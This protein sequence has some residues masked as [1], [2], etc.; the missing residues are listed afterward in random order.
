MVKRKSKNW[1]KIIA[2]VMKLILMSKGLNTTEQNRESDV[3]SLL[4]NFGKA[5][6]PSREMPIHLLIRILSFKIS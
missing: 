2:G 6:V 4:S 1:R 5:D 3:F